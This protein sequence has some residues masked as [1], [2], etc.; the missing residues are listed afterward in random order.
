M[1][2]SMLLRRIRPFARVLV[3]GA[4]LAATVLGLVPPVVGRSVPRTDVSF[5]NLALSELLPTRVGALRGPRGSVRLLRATWSRPGVACAESDFTMAGLTWRQEG[6]E[7]VEAELAWADTAAAVVGTGTTTEP[8]ALLHAD[9]GDGPDPGSPDDSGIQGTSPVWTGG[10]RCI[11]FRL[12]LP[13]NDSLSGLRAVFVDASDEGGGGTGVTAALA[14]AWGAVSGIWGFL[15]PRPAEAMTDRPDIITRAEWGANEGL[16]RC[17]PYYADSLKAAYVHHTAGSNTY[18]RDQADNV[19]R[20]IHAFHV[21][22]RGWC[23]IAYNFLIDRYGRVFEGRFGGMTRPLIGGHAAGFNTGTTGVA[24]M[25]EFTTAQPPPAMIQAFM[26]LLAWR[27]DVAHLRPTAWTKLTSSGGG[28]SRYGAGETVSVRVINGHR[29]TSYTACPGERLYAKLG[30]IRK[31]A[32]ALGLPKLY[33]PTRSRTTLE[34]GASTVTYRANLSGDLDWFADILDAEANLVRRMTGHGTQIAATWDG[35]ADD[36]SE[37]A[38][39]FYRVK[40][41]ARAAEGPETRPGWL[42]AVAC[43][44]IGG[45]GN[46]L[47][48]GTSGDDIL[49]G[50]GGNDLLRGGGGDDVLFGGPGFD[51]TDHSTAAS[52]VAVSLAAGTSSGQGADTLSSIEAASGSPSADTLVGSHGNN[53]LTGGG[54]A[55]RLVGSGGDDLL[56]GGNGM[57]SADY[58]ASG[59]R[60][61]V[62]LGNGTASGNGKDSLRSVE[63]VVGSLHRDTLLGDGGPNVLDGLRGSDQIRGRDGNDTLRGGRGDDA[64]LGGLGADLLTGGRGADQLTGSSGMDQLA[65]DRGNDSLRCKDGEADSVDGGD[66]KDRAEADTDLDVLTSVERRI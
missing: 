17:G 24:A 56:D 7:E 37:V 48:T 31:G 51:T 18:T 15:A 38:P 43:S 29:D 46:D 28:T 44:A 59:T 49:C 33:N 62:D 10:A 36:G 45:K 8:M 30:E 35:R 13:A 52:G 61:V 23:D 9:P 25:G 21:R 58:S 54:G 12:R 27:L 41:W 47:V 5:R 11:G 57:D 39:G 53:R 34:P 32:E 2:P 1:E 60:L 42:E 22:G 14:R 64:L 4:L 63:N 66:G 65:G 55:D 3:A 20:A 50:V 40:M 6:E 26:E 19:V 16:R